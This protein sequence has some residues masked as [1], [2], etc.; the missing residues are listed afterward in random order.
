M[1]SHNYSS[2]LIRALF[3]PSTAFKQLS[4]DNPSP[5]SVLFKY[6]LWLLLL[7]PIFSWIGASAFGW[8]VG[9][10]EPIVLSSQSLTA[11]SVGY[12]I[13][14]V[15]GFIS[16][17]FICRWMASTYGAKDS[18]GLHFALITVV[19]APLA[20]ASIAHLYPNVFFNVLILIPAMIWSM[21]LLFT[22]IP[23]VLDISP[24]KGMLMAS[25][26][27]GWLLVAAVSLLGI[28]MGLW[29]MGIG[30]YLGV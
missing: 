21:Y 9:A 27:V 28:S 6:S 20:V 19:A 14:L 16:T 1:Y 24:E 26:L 30:P 4:S 8:R 29:T 23:I 12:F 3:Q 17:V 2:I 25:S 7:P 10:S 15:F 5:L 18:L 13:A 22:G 11:I